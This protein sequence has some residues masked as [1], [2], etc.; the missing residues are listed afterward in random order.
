[1]ARPIDFEPNKVMLDDQEAEI[2]TL[3]KKRT[4]PKDLETT[5]AQSYGV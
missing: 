3:Q 5:L 1:M 4:G 2:R